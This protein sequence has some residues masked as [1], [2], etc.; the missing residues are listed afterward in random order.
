[1]RSKRFPVLTLFLL[2]S[3]PLSG[4]NDRPYRGLVRDFVGVNTNVGAYDNRIVDD[5]ARAAVWM[6]EY[7]RWE[8]FEQEKDV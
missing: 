6:R 4:Q 2:A 8:F 7:H 5:L 3:V 1:M